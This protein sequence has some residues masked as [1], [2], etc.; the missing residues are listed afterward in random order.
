CLWRCGSATACSRQL[1]ITSDSRCAVSSTSAVMPAGMYM[2][3]RQPHAAAT[4]QRKP[5]MW[6]GLCSKT[7][8]GSVWPAIGRAAARKRRSCG[9]CAMVPASSSMV[10]SVRITTPRTTTICTWIAG[11]SGCVAEP[12]TRRMS[13]A[14]QACSSHPY[15]RWRL[16]LRTL[17]RHVLSARP[18]AERRTGIRQQPAHLH[19]D[20]QHLL[21]LAEACELRE[22]VCADAEGF[23]L[24][25]EGTDVC[26]QPACAGRGAGI[27]CTL[28]RQRCAA[29][30]GET[31][32]HQ[33]AVRPDE[34]IRRR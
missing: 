17:A 33:L 31:R 14:S 30:E 20:Q 16:E 29:A 6:P 22:V 24:L 27:H 18:G 21:R 3:G 1:C 26:D 12:E 34:E 15:R 7:G 5:G 32:A 8:R 19:R 9:R 10:C 23:H 25:G 4:R 13:H 11:H 2:A 28:L